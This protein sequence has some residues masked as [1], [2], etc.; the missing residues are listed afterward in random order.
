M[1]DPNSLSDTSSQ[2]PVL[3]TVG[4]A[5]DSNHPL[6]TSGPRNI[7]DI[8]LE[9]QHF[10]EIIDSIP[11]W[12]FI[13]NDKHQ[14]EFVNRAY[15]AVYGIPARECVGKTAIELGADPECV[16]GNPE[17]GIA[18]FW[19]ADDEV[20]ATGKPVHISVEP[21]TV[22]GETKYLQ[23]MKKPLD[24]RTLFGFVH[25]VSYLKTVEKK[26]ALELRDNKAINSINE[27][28]RSGKEIGD[29]FQRVSQL[30]LDT[31]NA[32]KAEIQYSDRGKGQTSVLA[33]KAKD[34][35][36]E[37][38]SARH[39]IRRI[40]VSIE[41]ANRQI[42][43]LTVDRCEGDPDFSQQDEQFLQ[44]VANQIAFQLN[45]RKLAEEIKHRAYHDSLTD[46]PNRDKLILELQEALN[47]STHKDQFCGLVFLDLDG[48]KTV[49]DTCLLYTSPSPRDQRGSRM[50]SS[51]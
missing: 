46:L 37:P 29:A 25:D 19:A 11:S 32:D 38:T 42:G 28:L 15:A 35:N 27:V 40:S 20:F 36:A 18:G 30:V 21:M 2:Q 47:I 8:E 5:T 14:Y 10:R 50:P 39:I 23:T 13:K 1:I 26:I 6:N 16:K 41:F 24:K 34:K 48:F 51:A 49:N 12:V 44:S 43:T 45:Q 17:K 4:D 31:L 33:K 9:N 7:S 3:V 22:N